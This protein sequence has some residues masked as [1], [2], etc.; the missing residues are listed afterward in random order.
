MGQRSTP[1][2]KQPQISTNSHKEKGNPGSSAMVF[3]R[4]MKLL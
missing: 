4:Y 3:A 2:Y 1:K